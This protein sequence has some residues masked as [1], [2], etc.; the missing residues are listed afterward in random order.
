[1]SLWPGGGSDKPPCFSH[2]T[3]AYSDSGNRLF[4]HLMN[5]NNHTV[6]PPSSLDGHMM[7]VL[8]RCDLF[9]NLDAHAIAQVLENVHYRLVHL[10]T[11]EI[12][13]T[14]GMAV[15]NLDIV[16]SGSL[17]TRMMGPSGKELRVSVLKPGILVAPAYLFGEEPYYPVS[18]EADCPTTLLRL[19]KE[20]FVTLV[21]T[22]R[23]IL[24]NFIALLCD[25]TAFITNKVRMLSLTTVRDKL[26]AFLLQEAQLQGSRKIELRLSRQQIAEMLGIQK[27]SVIRQFNIFQENGAIVINGK[28]ITIL[29]ADLLRK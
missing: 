21:D 15:Q 3:A 4:L 2:A 5:T 11:G 28:K 26:A 7:E 19:T 17:S 13:T 9:R 14:A 27:F 12:F 24:W 23:R 8:V 29:N 16:V 6:P 10:N 22:D 25:T 18:A 1:M 20:Q